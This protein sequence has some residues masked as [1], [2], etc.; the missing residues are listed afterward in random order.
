MNRGPLLEYGVPE[1]YAAD[2][3]P[4]LKRRI[5]LELATGLFDIV[6]YE[7]TSMALHASAA[8]V[9]AVLTIHESQ[10]GS[11]L[12]ELRRG[13]YTPRDQSLLVASLLEQLTFFAQAVPRRVQNLIALTPEDASE[14]QQISSASRVYVNT[15]GIDV[16]EAAAPARHQDT[17]RFEVLFV[18]NFRHPPNVLAVLFFAREVMP[19]IRASCPNAT[20]RVVGPFAPAEVK[21]LDGKNGT[22]VAGFVEDLPHAYAS[23]TVFVAPLMSGSGMRVK[24]LEA[25]AAGLP[26]IATE[27]AMNGIGAQSPL[28]YLRATSAAEFAAAVVQLLGNGELAERIGLEGRGLAQ[29]DHSSAQSARVREAIWERAIASAAVPTGATSAGTPHRRGSQPRGSDPL[30]PETRAAEDPSRGKT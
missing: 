26:V 2:Y 9:P 25:M 22:V 7:Y 1:R 24:V 16:P 27:L 6:D 30:D 28:H 21:D 10:I 11:T 5:E 12:T 23:A 29:R 17:V 20:F 15:I 8:A 19:S 18:G 13:S 3:T 14:L 4:E